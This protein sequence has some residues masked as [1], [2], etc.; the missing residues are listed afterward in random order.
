MKFID[1]LLEYEKDLT[2]NT[3]NELAKHIGVTTRTLNKWISKDA[4]PRKKIYLE[5]M[6]TFFKLS[7]NNFVKLREAEAIGEFNLTIKEFIEL[8]Q[9]EE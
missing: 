4:R 8:R 9:K 5:R 7:Y 2:G 6:A 3:K 1:T